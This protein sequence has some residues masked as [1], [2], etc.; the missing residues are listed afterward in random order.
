MGSFEKALAK[1]L[2]LTLFGLFFAL[3]AVQRVCWENA[4]CSN[5]QVL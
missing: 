1:I 2:T 5:M 4:I 3:F